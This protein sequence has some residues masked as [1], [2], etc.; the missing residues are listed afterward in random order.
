MQLDPVQRAAGGLL[1]EPRRQAVEDCLEDPPVSAGR[2]E[3]V[4]PLEI[5]AIGHCGPQHLVEEELDQ[6]GR[7]GPGAEALA[8]RSPGAE[9]AR[10]PVHATM[11]PHRPALPGDR[12]VA[13]TTRHMLVLF[14][15]LLALGLLEVFVF[16]QIAD[17]IGFANA[18]GLLILISLVGAWVVRREGWKV[19]QRLNLQLSQGRLPQA[20]VIDGVLVL[21]AG[22]LLVMP[23][24]VT[25]VAGM[26]LLLPPTRALARRVAQRR[27][28][29][30]VERVRATYRGRVY[31][32]T[33]T[34][35]QPPPERP[36]DR[37]PIALPPRDETPEPGS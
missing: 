22:V 16:A 37:P 34:D 6:L 26:L 1:P 7:R 32:A 31:D 2:V 30:R 17:A 20:E 4:E 3:H 25:D 11:L 14:V 13:Y 10:A 24:F 27:M 5:A 21:G 8:R 29:V 18:L 19:W 36:P 9:G 35:G 12:R 33:A 15:A 28:A 23:G